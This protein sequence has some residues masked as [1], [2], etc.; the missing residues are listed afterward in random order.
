MTEVITPAVLITHPGTTQ[1][2]GGNF[3]DHELQRTDASNAFG[4]NFAVY[5]PEATSLMLCLFDSQKQ[6]TRLPMK[7][8]LY[9]I[10]HLMVEG[11]SERQLYGFRADGRWAPDE[12]LRFNRHKLLMDPYAREVQGKVKW[13]TELYDYSG[14]NRSEWLMNQYDNQHLTLKSVVRSDAFDWQNVSRPSLSAPPQLDSGHVIY[15]THVKGFTQQHPDI[16][17][18]IRGTYLGMS[19]PVAIEYLLSLG[20]TT[21]ELMPVTSFVSEARLGKLGLKNYWGYNPLCMM[22][23]EPSY[24][25]SDPM[26]ELKTMVRELHRA[27]IRVILDVVFNHTCEAG[28]DGPVLSLRGLAEKEYYLLD[29]NDGHLQSTSYSGC[30]NTLNFDSMQSVKLLMDSL[31]YWVEHYHID[32]FRFDLA[33]TMARRHRQFDSR[34]AFFQAVHQDPILSQCQMI[35]EPWDLGPEGYRLGG[36][37]K[38]WQEWNDRYRDGSRAF[39]RGN[40]DQQVDLAWRMAGSSDLFGADRPLGSINYICSHDGFTMNDLVSYENRHNLAN[41][42]DNRDGDQHNISWNFG[43]EGETDDSNIR[44]QRAQAKRNLFTTLMLSK[45]TPMFLAGDEFCNGQRG[46]NNVY[47]QDNPIGWLNW[48]KIEK[49]GAELRRFVAKLI[50]F[51]KAYPVIDSCYQDAQGEVHYSVHDWFTPCGTRLTA[52]QLPEHKSGT[53]GIRFRYEDYHHPALIVLVNNT[54]TTQRFQFPDIDRNVCWRRV[55]STARGDH[56]HREDVLNYGWFDVIDN[57]ILVVE[58]Q[59]IS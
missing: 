59:S 58:E 53:L 46:N 3:I 26:I 34:S 51:R 45:G 2:L 25:V 33:S 14:M 27:G 36:F 8:G 42:E 47:C 54:N 19:H 55:L 44:E 38:L 16:P 12:G 17:E 13:C 31:R 5:A 40:L 37:P 50:E 39:W 15:E 9:G 1:F 41:G 6:E 10:W 22:A 48:P 32:G 35:A 56:F 52:G 4:V 30:G 29:H 57:S 11:V 21:V 24:A 20:I 49:E 23:P 7:K 43:V 28:S 18:D